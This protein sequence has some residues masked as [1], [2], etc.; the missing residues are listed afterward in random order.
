M[1]KFYTYCCELYGWKVDEAKLKEMT[2]KDEAALKAVNDK[3]EAS[4]EG[5]ALCLGLNTEIL[6]PGAGWPTLRRTLGRVKC[7]RRC[8]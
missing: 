2:A 8:Y 5:S 7:G 4:S 6:R 3:C 1:A